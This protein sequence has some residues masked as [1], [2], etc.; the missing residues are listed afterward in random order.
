[1]LVQPRGY[2]SHQRLR[3]IKGSYAGDSVDVAF[4]MA[5]KSEELERFD[6]ANNNSKSDLRAK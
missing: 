3:F 2:T 6:D 4:L 1:M 5:E